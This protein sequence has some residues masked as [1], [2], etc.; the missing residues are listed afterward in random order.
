[1]H[2]VLKTGKEGFETVIL[3]ARPAAGKSE[4]IDFFKKTPDRERL[5]RFHIHPFSEIDDFPMLFTWFEEDKILEEMG[6][7][8]L[9]T[10]PDGYFKDNYFW[11]IL[12]RRISLEYDKTERDLNDRRRERTILIEFSRGREH[13]G[14][15]SAFKNLSR[16]ILK[17][18][19]VIYVNVSYEESLRKNRR[20]FNPKKPDSILEHSLPDDKLEKL[21]KECDWNEFSAPDPQFLHVE[22]ITVP[23]VVFQNEDDVTTARGAPLS[24]RLEKCCHELWEGY[25]AKDIFI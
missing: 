14:Y 13:G 12:I 22:G 4:I 9:H 21:Y 20:R 3:I 15:Q 8:R 5:S 1:M 18:A 2:T 19:A 24:E 6:K 16:K 23:Y 17:S 11:D 7:P 10:T 25:R